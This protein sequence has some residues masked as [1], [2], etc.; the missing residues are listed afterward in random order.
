[1]VALQPDRVPMAEHGVALREFGQRWQIMTERRACFLR[2]PK[3]DRAERERD[4]R[5]RCP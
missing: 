3:M 2:E 4:D 1:M 5:A